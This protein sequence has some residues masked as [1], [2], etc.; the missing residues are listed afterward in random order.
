MEPA[1]KLEQTEPSDDPQWNAWYAGLSPE[2]R[3][4]FEEEFVAA[5]EASF[6]EANLE[7][8]KPL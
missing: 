8:A 4:A 7:D 3:T 6:D 5:Y 1:R 2:E